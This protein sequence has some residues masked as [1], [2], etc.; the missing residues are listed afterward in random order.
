MCTAGRFLTPFHRVILDRVNFERFRDDKLKCGGEKPSC[1][2]CSGKGKFCRYGCTE[3]EETV[4]RV[5]A[6]YARREEYA[7]GIAASAPE[8]RSLQPRLEG[9]ITALGELAAAPVLSPPYPEQINQSYFQPVQSTADLWG[10]DRFTATQCTPS[11]Y[12]PTDCAPTD[13]T[14]TYY[15][16]NIYTSIYQTPSYQTPSYQTPS[17]Q[18][19]NYQ[20]PNYQTPSY[21]TPT[22]VAPIQL[23]PA[24]IGQNQ[25]DPNNIDG[26]LG[27]WTPTPNF[28]PQYSPLESLP[29]EWFQHPQ[30][31]QFAPREV[32]QLPSGPL[33]FREGLG[34]TNGAQT[35]QPDRDLPYLN[36]SSP[37]YPNVPAGAAWSNS[38]FPAQGTPRWPDN[39]GLESMDNAQMPSPHVERVRSLADIP[40][41]MAPR[42]DWWA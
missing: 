16:P 17:Y 33:Q 21:P 40:A 24:Q 26:T 41:M 28:T 36:H 5:A 37:V 11:N 3:K 12:T 9:P 31:S 19:P 32:S 8:P 34:F 20:T 7:L 14:P 38:D 30:E 42:E 18:T 23:D 2:R 4:Q 39:F 25:F 22:Q 13:Y 35:D 15:T 1:G 6:I 10:S 27:N 29:D